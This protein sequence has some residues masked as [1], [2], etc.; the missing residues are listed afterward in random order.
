VGV[1]VPNVR[2]EKGVRACERTMSTIVLGLM[3]DWNVLCCVRWN[4]STGCSKPK[5]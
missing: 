1:R 3:V 4:I 5:V 2:K